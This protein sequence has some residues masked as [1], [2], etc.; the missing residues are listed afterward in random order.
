MMDTKS[1][2]LTGTYEMLLERNAEAAEGDIS[3]TIFAKAAD[4]EDTAADEDAP[5]LAQIDVW[6]LEVGLTSGLPG[7][8]MGLRDVGER[9]LAPEAVEAE[10]GA[11]MAARILLALYQAAEADFNGLDLEGAPFRTP[12]VAAFSLMARV[13][14]LIA[15]LNTRL[16]GK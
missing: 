2:W 12:S 3:V 7:W 1:I 6:T 16:Y 13:S 8:R 14:N 9:G 15:S 4:P 11:R 10:F 5:I